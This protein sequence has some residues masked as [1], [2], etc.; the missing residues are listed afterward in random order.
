MNTGFFENETSEHM[1]IPFLRL[2]FNKKYNPARI[3]KPHRSNCKM[4]RH[5]YKALGAQ[6]NMY[7]NTYIDGAGF[8]NRKGKAGGQVKR[9]GGRRNLICATRVKFQIQECW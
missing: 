7:K 2:R 1:F 6:P 4:G 3:W 8:G 9:P 5:D